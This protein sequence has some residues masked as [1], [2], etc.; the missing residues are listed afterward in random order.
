MEY[1]IV[2][3][4]STNVGK[5]TFM[6]RKRFGM[7]KPYIEPTIGA[8]YYQFNDV[9]CDTKV[10]IHMWDTA[11]QERYDS[12]GPLYYRN[13]DCIFLMFDLQD[14]NSLVKA[15]CWFDEIRECKTLQKKQFLL[16]GTKLDLDVSRKLQIKDVD[17]LFH[18]QIEYIEISSKN[19]VNI[20][21]VDQIIHENISVFLKH[22][23]NRHTQTHEV[24]EENINYKTMPDATCC[25]IM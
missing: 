24:T 1:K 21:L 10:T 6:H 8:A 17:N 19:N 23:K 12:L 20:N 5:T 3:I 15:K 13:A 4:G 22:N 18:K 14:E 11:G 2:L 7:F 25:I 9:I 16:I